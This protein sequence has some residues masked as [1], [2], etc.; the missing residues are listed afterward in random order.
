MMTCDDFRE[1]LKKLRFLDLPHTIDLS[2]YRGDL[3][4]AWENE[5]VRAFFRLTDADAEKVW[6]EIAPE[7]N[8]LLAGM[9]HEGR[10]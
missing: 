5:P 6:A 7:G 4:A 8:R 10:A 2:E 1:A 9:F 3:K